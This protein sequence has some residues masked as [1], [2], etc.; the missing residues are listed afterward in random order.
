MSIVPGAD[1]R[2]ARQSDR[3]KGISSEVTARSFQLREG[4]GGLAGAEV[5]G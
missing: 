1:Q 3:F 4:F 5:G 2:E